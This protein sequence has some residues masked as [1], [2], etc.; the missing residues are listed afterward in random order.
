M[1]ITINASTYLLISSTALRAFKILGFPSNKNGIVMI[2]TVSKPRSF[3]T[4]ATIGAAPVPVPPPIPAVTN[5]ILVLS[6]NKSPIS[7][8]LSSAASLAFLGSLPAP[9]PP[10]TVGP[11]NNFLGTADLPRA[12]LSVLHTTNSTFFTLDLYILSIALFPPP[13]TPITIISGVDLLSVTRSISSM[14]LSSISIFNSS[15]SIRLI[16]YI[17]FIRIFIKC[18]T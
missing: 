11:I 3:A 17:I 16:S 1:L 18:F 5:T 13:P 2:P 8:R 12:C 10:V 4:L 15:F 6:S 7:A 9:R 14:L